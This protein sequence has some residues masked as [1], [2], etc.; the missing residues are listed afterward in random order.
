MS[1][2]S[3]EYPKPRAWAEPITAEEFAKFAP[4]S[5]AL[6]DGNILSSE[7]ERLN[8]LALLLK[9]CGLEEAAML[10]HEEDWHAAA[11]RAGHNM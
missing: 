4:K 11:D 5:L 9:N 10:C 1:E 7:E 6:I 8:L 3:P 2:E